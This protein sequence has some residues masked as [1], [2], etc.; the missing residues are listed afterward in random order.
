MDHSK[1]AWPRFGFRRQADDLGNV[2]RPTMTFTGSLAHGFGT[3]LFMAGRQV[4]LLHGGSLP[5]PGLPADQETHT[6]PPALAFPPC[7]SHHQHCEVCKEPVCSQVLGPA[8]GPENLKVR[9]SVSLHGGA[10]GG[11]W[12]AICIYAHIYTYICA[13]TQMSV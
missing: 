10:H 13:Y 8:G 6:A 12:P 9:L 7:R 5:D 4:W 2:V 3:Y 11:H 1:I